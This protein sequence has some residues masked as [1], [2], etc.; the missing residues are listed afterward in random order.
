VHGILTGSHDCDEPGVP[1]LNEDFLGTPLKPDTEVFTLPIRITGPDLHV[2]MH[3][4]LACDVGFRNGLPAME[5]LAEIYN[6]VEADM[7]Q[8]P[9]RCADGARLPVAA[10]A[11]RSR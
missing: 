6:W 10:Y 1:R 2:D 8:W 7:H 5:A 11:F 3:I 4:E 9:S